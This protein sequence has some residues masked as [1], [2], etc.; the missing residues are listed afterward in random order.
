MGQ[1]PVELRVSRKV[2]YAAVKPTAPA[3]SFG[4]KHERACSEWFLALGVLWGRVR[5]AILTCRARA[6]AR[7]RQAQLL[8]RVSEQ[9]DGIALVRGARACSSD[10][11]CCGGRRC[12]RA[13]KEQQ[14]HH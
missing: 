12:T 10:L 7:A 1:D 14:Q 6:Q 5:A 3:Y 8:A 11:A 4:S 9:H 13:S 2:G